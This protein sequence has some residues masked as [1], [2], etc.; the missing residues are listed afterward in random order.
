M[1]FLSRIRDGISAYMRRRREEQERLRAERA[2]QKRRRDFLYR[3]GN[4][5]EDT[6]AEMFDPSLFEL[7]HRT[8]RDDETDGRYVRGMELP[9]L[10]FREI[11]TGRRFWVECKFRAHPREDWSIEWC[12]REQLTAYKRTMHEYREPVLAMIGLGGTVQRPERIYCLDVGEINYTTLFYGTYKDR[13][14]H[15]KPAGLDVLLCIA[16]RNADGHS[17]IISTSKRFQYHVRQSVQEGLLCRR[18]VRYCR[19]G[20]PQTSYHRRVS[21]RLACQRR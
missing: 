1:S 6:V 16:H 14:V 19:T 10:R 8:P 11:S 12:S 18:A 21:L 2:E 13:R 7:I 5:F 15:M 3:L 20:R 17:N 4:D 9:D